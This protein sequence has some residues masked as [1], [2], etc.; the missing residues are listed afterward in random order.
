M[1]KNTKLIDFNKKTTL[2]MDQGKVF[3]TVFAFAPASMTNPFWG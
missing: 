1:I 3:I 2:N